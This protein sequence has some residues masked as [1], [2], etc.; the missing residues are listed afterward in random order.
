MAIAR[1]V[2]TKVCSVERAERELDEAPGMRFADARRLARHRHN[3]S[4][5]SDREDAAFVAAA[6]SAAAA[7]ADVIVEYWEA[8]RLANDV[9]AHEP[10]YL[11]H[12]GAR[13]GQLTYFMMNALRERL[14]S[15]ARA[16]FKFCYVVADTRAEWLNFIATHPYLTPFVT[17]GQLDT[18][19]WDPE[20]G[21]PWHLRASGRC[22]TRVRNP[23]VVIAD[24]TFSE[25]TH[26]LFGFQ[27]GRLLDARVV[28]PAADN[29]APACRWHPIRGAD[30]LP[31]SWEPLFANYLA[32][33]DSTPMLVPSGALRCVDHLNSLAAG[34]Y[35]LLCVDRGVV[36]EQALRFGECVDFADGPLPVNFHALAAHQ[37]C[38]GARVW[39]DRRRENGPVMQLALSGGEHDLYKDGF[40]ALVRRLD[41]VSPDDSAAFADTVAQSAEPL[42]LERRLLLVRLSRHDPRVLAA[43]FEPL[44]AGIDELTGEACR[45]WRD[46]LERTWANYFPRREGDP[47]CFNLGVLAAHLGHW[48]LAKEAFRL[49]LAVYGNDAAVLYHL[50]LC[51]A[52]TGG[53]PAALALLDQALEHEPANPR[54]RD[55]RCVLAERLRAW[56][57]TPWY[58]RE[59]ACDAAL[60]LEPIGAEH[61]AVLLYQLRD[62]QIGVMTRLPELSTPED[63]ARWLEEEYREP[64]RATYAVMHAEHGFVGVVSLRRHDEAGYFYFWIGT[65]Y[66]GMGL[67]RRA[68]ALLFRHARALGIADIFTSAYADNARSR[69][70]LAHLGFA[71]IDIAACEPDQD[72]LFFRLAL[73]DEAGGGAEPAVRLR[74]L[75]RAIQSPIEFPEVPA[76]SARRA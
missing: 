30:W 16:H 9:D 62:P 45:L 76:P 68:A 7:Y 54:Y 15:P 32:R 41:S 57:A 52:S 35:L 20:R 74:A 59:L 58:R 72:L 23:L 2:E 18:A 43:A 4:R 53:T 56:N 29:D 25:L 10:L 27:Y 63:A 37:Q 11:L 46:A 64:G 14:A 24:R 60:T 34:R 1:E 33:L 6:P 48:V 19:Q 71:Q 40:A 36:T 66:Q 69:R 21:G 38:R 22:V 44:L 8:A 75:C 42:S 61:L 70:A 39:T 49:G 13:D 50:G 47:F 31:P 3:S 5:V 26:D 28:D 51:E 67:G 17:M 65:D 73:T 12:L 55:F